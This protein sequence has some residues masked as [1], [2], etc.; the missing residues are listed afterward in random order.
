MQTYTAGDR[1]ELRMSRFPLSQRKPEL[2]SLLLRSARRSAAGV[3]PC[4]HMP[5][6]ACMRLYLCRSTRRG[7]H[8]VSAVRRPAETACWRVLSPHGRRVPVSDWWARSQPMLAQRR[9]RQARQCRRTRDRSRARAGRRTG[10]PHSPVVVW[11][12]RAT[13]RSPVTPG[14]GRRVGERERQGRSND[15]A[16]HTSRT[17]GH[18]E[19]ADADALTSVWSDTAVLPG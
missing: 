12:S 5:N 1:A 13:A 14:R 18:L 10:S 6:A 16:W 8:R 15:A 17:A 3:T 9:R 19:R 11:Q 2:P 4:C 7:L